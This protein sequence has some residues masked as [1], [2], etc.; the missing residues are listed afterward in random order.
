MKKN[1]ISVLKKFF[2]KLSGQEPEGN[3]LVEVI[4]NGTKNLSNDSPSS[5][6]FVVNENN[7]YTLN[8]TW[9]EIA[10]ALESQVVV[11]KTP[12]FG[13]TNYSYGYCMGVFEDHGY[14]V[15]FTGVGQNDSLQQYIA[16]TTDGYPMRN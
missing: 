16:E 9:Q 11:I 15:T 3:N 4:N 10:D 14:S 1:L 7:S 13:Q 2:N 5:G 8:K 6:V 12:T